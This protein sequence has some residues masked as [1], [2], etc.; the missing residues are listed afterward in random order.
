MCVCVCLFLIANVA[1]SGIAPLKSVAEQSEW[2]RRTACRT[3]LTLIAHCLRA[4]L[5][6]VLQLLLGSKHYTRSI[7]MFACGCIFYEL[8]T[9]SPLFPG[10]EVKP[11]PNASTAASSRPFQEN[12]MKEVMRVLGKPSRESWPGLTDMPHYA[13]IQ[14]WP[15]KD[16]PFALDAR[17]PTAAAGGSQLARDLLRSML[18]YDPARR[19][20]AE[21]ALNHPYFREEPRAD[22]NAFLAKD[23]QTYLIY[24]PRP[25]KPTAQ[26]KRMREHEGAIAAAAAAGG[27]AAAAA[28]A[29]S[30]ASHPPL[31]PHAAQAH[32]SSQAQHRFVAGLA[33]DHQRHVATMQQNL[34]YANANSHSGVNGGGL[35]PP[36]MPGDIIRTPLLPSDSTNPRS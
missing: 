36:P 22:P 3:A 12:Q 35:M 17:L 28:A 10:Q 8:M 2:N 20:T 1:A 32:A 23:G 7:D 26:S 31:H 27:A 34:L 14:N 15:A 33:Q 11:P 24:P 21:D 5:L 18:A 25:A 19:I 30:L 6:C 13:N 4:V 29:A 16:Y 9:C